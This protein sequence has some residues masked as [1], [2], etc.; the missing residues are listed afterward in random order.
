MIKRREN[1]YLLVGVVVLRDRF[2]L[3]TTNRKY[4]SKYDR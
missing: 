4:K 3:K 1:E 2:W